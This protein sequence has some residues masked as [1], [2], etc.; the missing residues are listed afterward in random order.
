MSSAARS[1]RIM[2][3][4]RNTDV[5][6]SIK[7]NA[8]N[9][10]EWVACGLLFFIPLKF[11]A[12]K[13][14]FNLTFSRLFIFIG[15]AVIILRFLK[16]TSCTRGCKIPA[17][18]SSPHAII[19]YIYLFAS[20]LYSISIYANEAE[21]MRVLIMGARVLEHLLIVPL[22]YFLLTKRLDKRLKIIQL[23]TS[24]WWAL[25]LLGFVQV[26]LDLIGISISYESIGEPSNENRADL[27]GGLSV[28]RASSLFGE[29][30]DLAALVLPIAA[31]RA[32]AFHRTLSTFE[33]CAV[34]LIGLITFSNTFVFVLV[35]ILIGSFFVNFRL[36]RFI[37][38][39]FAFSIFILTIILNFEAVE[40]FIVEWIPR[41]SIL[42]EIFSEDALAGIG[43]ELSG[44]VSQ[45]IS[46]V[47][48][49]PYFIS[50]S[51]L[52][53][54]GLLGHGLGASQLFLR[55]FAYDYWGFQNPDVTFGT[56]FSFF[57][58]LIDIGIVGCILFISF[59]KSSIQGLSGCGGN[60]EKINRYP[61]FVLG[62][63]L[64]NDGYIFVMFFI[65][66]SALRGR[67]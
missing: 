50:G 53:A 55:S 67:G 6:P 41:F 27:I 10:D 22:I 11:F 39:I 17:N 7:R 21:W 38:L 61:I 36:T 16:A 44:D 13:A 20:L 32:L 63:S 8:L 12:F 4:H 62:S 43:S 60:E 18:F 14:E 31:M 48:I 45:Q 57:I 40:I 49:L 15:L 46:D 37:W 19:F 23:V 26:G 59:I 28:L 34:F 56:R 65:L 29:P 24:S 9:F 2:F 47:I 1:R 52:S 54:E 35:T 3:D 33:W 51:W 42:F 25:C 66:C 64:L 30:R 5:P 58:F